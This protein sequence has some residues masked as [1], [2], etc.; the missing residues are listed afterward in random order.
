MRGPAIL[1]ILL[2]ILIG[3]VLLLSQSVG[4]VPVQT[5]ETDVAANGAAN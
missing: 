4:D 5:I 1:I 3:A 2:I